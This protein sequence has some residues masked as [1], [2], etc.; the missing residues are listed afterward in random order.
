MS[1][2]EIQLCHQISILILADALNS[3]SAELQR[4]K[5]YKK[6]ILV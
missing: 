2:I 5:I 4:Y 3:D 6:N 1:I